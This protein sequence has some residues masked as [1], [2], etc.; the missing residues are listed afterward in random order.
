M[1]ER[2]AT[3]EYKLRFVKKYLC[4]APKIYIRDLLQEI[5][6]KSF[7]IGSLVVF[8]KENVQFVNGAWNEGAFTVI[9]FVVV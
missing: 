7:G 3:K 5:C 8:R 9:I 1:T 4:D 2:R 6:V